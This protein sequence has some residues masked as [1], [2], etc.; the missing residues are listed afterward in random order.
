MERQLVLEKKAGKER[1]EQH[2]MT[3]KHLEVSLSFGVSDFSLFRVSIS[4]TI[5][6]HDLLLKFLLLSMSHEK[7]EFS[8]SIESDF[9]F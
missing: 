7:N 2:K 4:L 5:F 3:V 1:E 9:D 8:L 6:L